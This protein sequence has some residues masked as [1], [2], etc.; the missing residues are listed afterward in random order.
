M[1]R[2]AFA[3][4]SVEKNMWSVT[5]RLEFTSSIPIADGNSMAAIASLAMGTKASLLNISIQALMAQRFTLYWAPSA[6]A[7]VGIQPQ[8][9]DDLP[10]AGVVLLA[11]GS[12]SDRRR[13]APTMVIG[14]AEAYSKFTFNC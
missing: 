4:K 3:E 11:A 8:D 12:V 5:S 7:G 13:L 14:D 6:G 1:T 10:Q 2:E 9:D